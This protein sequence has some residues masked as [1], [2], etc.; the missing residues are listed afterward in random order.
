MPHC[1]RKVRSIVF[2]SLLLLSA[3]YSLADEG[4]NLFATHCSSCHSIGGG[5][6]GGPDLKGVTAL[7]DSSWL[8]RIIT[9]PD[10]LTAG[11]D[12]TQQALVKKYGYEMPSLGI[13]RDDAKQIIAFLKAADGSRPKEKPESVTVRNSSKVNSKETAEAVP[14]AATPVDAIQV[15]PPEVVV[16]PEIIAAG[17]AFF[18]G[19]KQ[20]AKGGAP[21]GSCHGFGYPGVNGGNFAADLSNI[22]ERMGEQGMKGVLRALKFP[23]MKKIYAD[24]Q[25]TDEEITALIAFAKDG[26]VRKVSTT[27]GNFP[28]AG[29]ILLIGAIVILTVYKRRIR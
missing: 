12:P 2:I 28:L 5:D 22:Y 4:K 21:C 11:K 27:G 7:R 25:L 15:K 13:S 14:V 29:V 19:K 20:F 10:K 17:L 3:N 16:T 18:T 26:A 23:I 6:E 8:L 1:I 9:E 24:K